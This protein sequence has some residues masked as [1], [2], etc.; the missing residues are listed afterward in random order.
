MGIWG[1]DFGADSWG[2]ALK[3]LLAL[4]SYGVLRSELA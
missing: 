4:Y 3:L 1:L 2:L